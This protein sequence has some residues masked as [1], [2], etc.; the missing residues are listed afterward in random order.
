MKG[1]KD[2]DRCSSLTVSYRLRIW[3][4]GPCWHSL[5]SLRNL[6]KA[7]PCWRKNATRGGFESSHPSPTSC[8]RLCFLYTLGDV[9]T[10]SWLYSAHPLPCLLRILERP[11]SQKQ[12]FLPSFAFGHGILLLQWKLTNAREERE[13][14]RGAAEGAER[15]RVLASENAIE[16]L[17]IV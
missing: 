8:P 16:F 14:G 4:P 15:E 12:L 10:T 3:A 5:W 6:P 11:I 2:T 7:E 13:R 9:Q 17:K 1:R